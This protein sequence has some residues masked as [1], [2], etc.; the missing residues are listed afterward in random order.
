VYL[1]VQY[2]CDLAGDVLV[3]VS[4]Y[5][6]FIICGARGRRLEGVSPPNQCMQDY[7]F[8]EHATTCIV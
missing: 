5:S 1:D 6:A 2:E 4:I 8:N 7:I 3:A